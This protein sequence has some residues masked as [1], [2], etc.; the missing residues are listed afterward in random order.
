MAKK[1][2]Q[3]TQTT[4]SKQDTNFLA[5]YE[6]L[7]KGSVSP[8]QKKY[9]S[10][11]H[12]SLD[13]LLSEGKGIELGTYIELSSKSGLGKCVT[14]DSI[15]FVN[16]KITRI[17]DDINEL[18]YVAAN[19]DNEILSQNNNFDKFSH[20]YKERV[21]CVVTIRDVHGNSL[22]GTPEHPVLVYRDENKKEWVK[23][24]DLS[25]NDK[26]V[27]TRMD[28][29]FIKKVNSNSSF[30][31][32]NQF[33][34]YLEG[35][36]L[37]RRQSSWRYGFM[38]DVSEHDIGFIKDFLSEH[39]VE[40]NFSND[41]ENERCLGQYKQY[42]HKKIG[43]NN[44][45]F[46]RIDLTDEEYKKYCNECFYR[47]M[48]VE[49]LFAKLAGGLDAYSVIGLNAN[50]V[51][52]KKIS[53][54]FDTKEDVT[55]AQRMLALFGIIGHQSIVNNHRHK[56]CL[57]LSIAS[58]LAFA[59]LVK[60]FSV[61]KQNE[62]TRYI[63]LFDNEYYIQEKENYL[64][65]S[66]IISEARDC[67]VYDYTI[68][69]SH[70]FIANGVVSHNTTLILDV[71]KHVCEQGY[72]VIYID[73]ETG[74]SDNLLKKV[75]LKEYEQSGSFLIFPT[76]TFNKAGA[77]LD[78]VVKDP[79]VALI[80]V[81]SITQLTPDELV[82]DGKKISDGQIGIQARYTGNLLKRY[83][84]RI[85]NSEK[86][87]IFINQMRTHIPTGYGNA[88]EAPA[89][90]N[91]QQFTMDIRLIMKKVEEIKADDGHPIGWINKISA[92]K[93]RCGECFKDYTLKLIFGKGI[94]E[95]SEYADWLIGNGVV[96]KRPAG[97][98]IITWKGNEIKLRGLTN[99]E[100]WVTENLDEIRDFV[101]AHGGLNTCCEEEL[102][103]EEFGDNF[104]EEQK[105][106]EF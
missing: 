12:A 68:P 13:S 45:Y 71:V 43:K 29:G 17:E 90:A 65:V 69:E 15:V 10:T 46:I 49:E 39:G 34:S 9:I 37:I 18:G 85:N 95:N 74:L 16:N 64:A 77:I 84:E 101:N 19:T 78:C 28:E 96:E 105:E 41:E 75:G 62:L 1:K 67:F 106:V 25:L 53:L 27:M 31:C 14:G 70:C 7:K 98:F 2:Q 83:R 80:I 38:L 55:D 81:D 87:I 60:P 3:T 66:E 5:L 88:Y 86:S 40:P 91:A 47:Q 23:L 42:F 82:E 103:E 92:I 36:N 33:L 102:D 100:N 32:R 104:N 94:D 6:Q 24:K 35:Y 56:Y 76:T 57:N 58:S 97:I 63:G 93:N 79:E 44:K 30:E 21:S 22:T 99:F 51:C 4:D 8:T 89:G 59:F 73:S 54:F 50:D 48:P 11:G 52:Y 20:R 72:R 61:L 26:I